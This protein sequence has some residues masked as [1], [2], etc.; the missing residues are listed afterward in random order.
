MPTNKVLYFSQPKWPT[1]DEAVDGGN[2][3]V[4]DP[5]TNTTTAV[6]P[7]A[8]TWDGRDDP[9]ADDRAVPANLW[10]AGQ[11][12]LADGRVLVVGGNLRVPAQRRQRR[13]QRLQGR[14]AGS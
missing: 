8:V 7:P 5:L 11:T 2:A 14:Q 3:H 6:P 12:L 1:E 9:F 10:C 13:G 4:W